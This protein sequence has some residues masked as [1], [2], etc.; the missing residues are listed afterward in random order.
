MI[1]SFPTPP[2]VA[3]DNLSVAGLSSKC[4]VIIGPAYNSMLDMKADV[5]YDLIFIDAD[6]QSNAKY[7]AEAKRLVRTGGVI[8]RL[9]IY[10]IQALLC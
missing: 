10:L 9:Y 3:E 1:S 2:Q 5:P 7:F 4:K 6:K 8:V